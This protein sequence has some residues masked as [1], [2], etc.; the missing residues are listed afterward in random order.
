[1]FEPKTYNG[2]DYRV[3]QGIKPPPRHPEYPNLGSIELKLTPHNIGVISVR[4]AELYEAIKFDSIRLYCAPG[5]R[6]SSAVDF[7]MF[8]PYVQCVIIEDR[9]ETIDFSQF[10][11]FTELLVIWGPSKPKKLRL[12]AFPKIWQAAFRQ[13][14]DANVLI[15]ASTLEYLDLYQRLHIEKTGW[16]WMHTLPNLKSFSMIQFVIESLTG[17]EEN[18]SIETLCV[19]YPRKLTSL[20]GIEAFKSLKRLEIEGARQLE[21]MSAIGKL[22][23]LKQLQIIGSTRPKSWD[24]LYSLPNLEWVFFNGDEVWQHGKLTKKFSTS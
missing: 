12:A 13:I 21:D 4:A 18:S 20:N 11:C 6:F 19:A 9:C 2:I 7:T 17:I 3:W 8:A 24:F 22:E 23:N 14:D 5:E 15:N 16:S 1:M 10:H